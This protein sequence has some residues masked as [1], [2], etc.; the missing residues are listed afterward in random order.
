MRG[1]VLAQPAAGFVQAGPGG[2]GRTGDLPGGLVGVVEQGDGLALPGGQADDRAAQRVGTVQVLSRRQ[3][4]RRCRVQ[5][6]GPV[7]DQGQRRT[8]P[9]GAADI[10]HD[11][12]QPAGEPAGV[13]QPVQ[14]D[15]RLQEGVL[16]GIVDVVRL[17]AQPCRARHRQVPL[18]Q[19]PERRRIAVA[20]QPD[21]VTVRDVHALPLL[22][23]FRPCRGEFRVAQ[24]D[25]AA[26]GQR[27]AEPDDAG[28]AGDGHRHLMPG[29][30]AAGGAGQAAAAAIA[31]L[32]AG[33]VD[34]RACGQIQ[35]GVTGDAGGA[36]LSAEGDRAAAVVVG[37]DRL[38]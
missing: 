9:L 32:G 36:Q 29:P 33:R 19:Q 15:E 25:A 30:V 7:A 5:V 4:V 18:D 27:D 21:Q 8:A 37:E 1:D 23:S 38:D 28:V 2:A 22:R 6:L 31:Q 12:A 17:R 10:G 20:G 13:A 16:H 14:R 11:A 3:A 34:G 24:L 35:P 26:A